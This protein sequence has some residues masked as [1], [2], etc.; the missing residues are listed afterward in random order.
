M[1]GEAAQRTLHPWTHL[2]SFCPLQIHVT[3]W[4]RKM[5]Q[6]IAQNEQNTTTGPY[7][8]F[9]EDGQEAMRVYC[10]QDTAGGGWTL[11][12]SG[13][14]QK[15]TN[16]RRSKLDLVT[17][18]HLTCVKIPQC[19]RACVYSCVSLVRASVHVCVRACLP[20]CAYYE[21]RQLRNRFSSGMTTGLLT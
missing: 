4:H 12:R 5:C 21:A 14:K 15:R 13:D 3:Y 18:Y 17:M 6:D 7:Y 2:G 11:V 8:V 10:D 20:V 9:P 1:V 19:D 16:Q